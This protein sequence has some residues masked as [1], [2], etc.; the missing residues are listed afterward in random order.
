M[1]IRKATGENI[2]EIAKIMLD[3]FSKYPFNEKA[4]FKD[5]LKSLLFY[6]RIG[7]IYVAIVKKKIVGVLVFKKEQFWEGKVII[8]E[9]L[10]VKEEFK[11]QGIGK[12]LMKELEFYAKNKGVKSIYFN[13]HKKSPSLKFYE[14]LDYRIMKNTIPMRKKLG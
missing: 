8:I 11:G 7:I 12:N 6:F 5:V 14:K 10:A 1:I 2:K 3:E 4:S 9:D 13:S